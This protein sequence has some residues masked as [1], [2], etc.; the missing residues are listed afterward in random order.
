MFFN[1]D[2]HTITVSL[3]LIA[4]QEDKKQ[5]DPELTIEKPQPFHCVVLKIP[6]TSAY[7]IPIA[8]LPCFNFPICFK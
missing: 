6:K 8:S 7:G 1:V 2:R 5:A 3:V 4:F